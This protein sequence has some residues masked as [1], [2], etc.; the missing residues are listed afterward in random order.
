MFRSSTSVKPDTSAPDTL[1]HIEHLLTVESKSRPLAVQVVYRSA[2]PFSLASSWSLGGR[3]RG[4]KNT[5]RV[6]VMSWYAFPDCT[7]VI[8]VSLTLQPRQEVTETVELTYDRLAAPVKIDRELTTV[9]KRTIVVREDTIRAGDYVNP[10][11][12]AE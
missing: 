9:S 1:E 11:A 8:P 4:D 7:I 12:R 2:D 10:P 5:D 3:R 6:K